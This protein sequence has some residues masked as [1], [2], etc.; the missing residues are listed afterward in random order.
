MVTGRETGPQ[1]NLHYLS[2]PKRSLIEQVNE[3][4]PEEEPPKLQLLSYENSALHKV[5]Q[6]HLQVRW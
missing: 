1:K 5:S 6:W 2:V 4:N 3:E